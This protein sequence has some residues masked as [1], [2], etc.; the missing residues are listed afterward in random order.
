MPLRGVVKTVGTGPGHGASSTV[1]LDVARGEVVAI[2]GS[3]GS[4]KTSLLHVLAGLE[5]PGS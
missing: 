4:G 2:T 3:S 1:E 5:P